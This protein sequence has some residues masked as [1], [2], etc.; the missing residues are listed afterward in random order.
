M[1]RSFSALKVA[2][3]VEAKMKSQ[4]NIVYSTELELKREET[5]RR[6]CRSNQVCCL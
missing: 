6:K 3:C 2:K 1:S 5:D 4:F